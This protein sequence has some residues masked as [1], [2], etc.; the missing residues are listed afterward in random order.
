MNNLSDIWNKVLEMMESK[1]S[2]ATINT[3][4]TDAKLV[5]FAD[6]TMI[7]TT[8]HQMKKDIITAKYLTTVQD[9]LEELFSS[10]IDVMLMTPEELHNYYQEKEQS[11]D[12]ASDEHTFENFIVGSSNKFAHAAAFA[13]ADNPAMIYNPLFIHGPSG[14]GKTH[15]LHAIARRIKQDHPEYKI[16]YISAE[17]F[18]N[19][20]IG[21]I[22]EGK[23][24]EFRQKYRSSDLLLVDDV[25]F[26]AGKTSTQEEFFHTF[27][28]LHD[29]H[30]QIVLTSDRPPKELTKLEERLRTRFESGLIA[31]ISFPDFETRCAIVKAKAKNLSLDLSYDIIELIAQK[32]TQS[33]RQL[34]GVVKKINALHTLMG[35]P[36]RQST[37][38]SAIEDVFKEHP[39]LNPTPEYIIEETSKFYNIPVAEIKGNRR[40]TDIIQ[41]RQVAMYISRSITS[42]S[43][44]E[45]GARFGGKDHTTVMHALNKMEEKLRS[46]PSLQQDVNTLIRT[47]KG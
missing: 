40:T 31:D 24:N 39:G 27:N 14:L 21:S 9:I 15:L 42:M 41:A 22:S 1:F 37:A 29:A 30:K 46:S 23:T 17:D 13:V 33:V 44:P 32:I 12:F 5:E 35:M 10:H 8:P 2:M 26:I 28:T 45:I 3:W 43:L 6:D 38:E 34:E 18:T 4:F 19:D 11:K 47:I 7:V 16:T 25:Q 20:L 36:L